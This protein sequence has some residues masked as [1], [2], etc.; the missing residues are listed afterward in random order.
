MVEWYGESSPKA[1]IDITV[2]MN[3]GKLP[4]ITFWVRL[5]PAA[6]GLIG[7]EHLRKYRRKL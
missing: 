1:V 5:E 2:R 4:P 6:L 7:V 3:L